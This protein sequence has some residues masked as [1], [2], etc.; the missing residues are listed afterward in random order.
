MTSK[1]GEDIEISIREDIC[2]KLNVLISNIGFRLF[3]EN[4]DEKKYNIKILGNIESI[5][6]YSLPKKCRL[7]MKGDLCDK[8]GR[9][10]HI[11]DNY[12]NLNIHLNGFDSFEMSSFSIYRFVDIKEI[13][14]I[15]IYP[16]FEEK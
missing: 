1:F 2:N 9:V 8:D 5:N 13:K 10:L 6:G 15:K 3:Y 4:D 16:K 11:I 14:S 7:K 12:G